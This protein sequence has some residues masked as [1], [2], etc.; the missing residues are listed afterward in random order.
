M[1]YQMFYSLKKKKQKQKPTSMKM[2]IQ[3]QVNE[4]FNIQHLGI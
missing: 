4:I 3:H 1:F 2:K